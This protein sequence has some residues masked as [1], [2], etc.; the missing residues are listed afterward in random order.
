MRKNRISV[1]VCGSRDWN[2]A[3]VIFNV[4][5]KL[6]SRCNHLCVISGGHR[7]ADSVAKE[8]AEANEFNNVRYVEFKANWDKY[9]RSAGPIRN[10]EMIAFLRRRKDSGDTT[11]V[12]AFKTKASSRGTDNVIRLCKESGVVLFIYDVNGNRIDF[13]NL[14]GD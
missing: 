7:G 4:L 13:D 10:R 1:I 14:T 8:W 6:K 5:N 2:R 11:L 9:D 3:S 12:L